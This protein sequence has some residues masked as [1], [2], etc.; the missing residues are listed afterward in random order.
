M[1]D[2]FASYSRSDYKNEDGETIPGN[3]I[4]QIKNVLDENN[5]PYWIDENG[6]INNTI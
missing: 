5:I 4:S 1:Y 6:V 3:I 2:V